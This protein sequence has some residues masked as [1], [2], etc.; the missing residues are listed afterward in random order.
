MGD[1][2]GVTAIPVSAHDVADVLRDQL[3]GMTQW[4]LHKLLYYVQGWHLARCGEAAFAERIEAWDD[5]PVVARLWA[6]E[7]YDRSRPSPRPVPAD[8]MATIRYVMT[9]YGHLSGD[10]L[11]E[12]MHREA[13]WADARQNATIPDDALVDW[14]TVQAEA[15]RLRD[16]R[17]FR[18]ESL[19][20]PVIDVRVNQ[21]IDANCKPGDG[22]MD[23][24]LPDASG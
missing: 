2:R 24:P 6:D 3:R 12:R 19:S 9:R 13:P 23:D 21:F 18:T 4:R 7:K 20:T 16:R 10:E 11:R 17:M 8:L 14:F 22:G 5:G 15:D 1:S